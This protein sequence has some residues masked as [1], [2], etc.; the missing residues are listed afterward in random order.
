MTPPL[1]QRRS[2]FPRGLV[3]GLT[4]A[5]TAILI[6]FVLLLALT[7]LLGREADRRRDAEQKL[8]QFQEIRS[9]LVERGIEPEAVLETI[10]NHAT[11]RTDADNW[12]ELIRRVAGQVTR[13][14]PQAIASRLD[15]AAEAL[16][17]HRT[18]DNILDEARIESTP[19]GLR[20]LAGI[21]RAG[22]AA[23]LTANEVRDAIAAHGALQD[24]L[25]ARG[26]ETTSKAV[27]NLVADA[28]HWRELVGDSQERDIERASQRIERLET[29]VQRLQA[30][31]RGGGG[32]DHPS[33][34][35]DTDNTVAYLFDVALTDVGFILQPARAPQH[36]G[37]RA[38]LP[39]ASIRSGQLLTPGQ[40]QEQTR[41][42]FDRSVAD[43]CRFFVRAFDLTAADQKEV[44]KERMRMLE[45]R[46][47]KNANPSGPPPA[48][49]PAPLRP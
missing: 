6:I 5:E 42:V 26:D 41:D 8:A 18:L 27:Q 33:C 37:K 16:E 49:D 43:G 1:G 4:M 2:S 10:R 7:A 17:I 9:V 31:V 15:E 13:P 46:F 14:S 30:Q 24:S 28:Q 21:A 48:V 36:D 34:W 12:R 29:Q 25:R 39:L 47:Y 3:L 45:S 19:D 44:Y 11:D 40:F 22:L 20:E 35:Y 38:S 23:N 32:T